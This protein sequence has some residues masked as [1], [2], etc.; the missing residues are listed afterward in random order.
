MIIYLQNVC[1]LEQMESGESLQDI[2]TKLSVSWC[3]D[4]IKFVRN[5]FSI[6]FILVYVNLSSICIH[7][8][9][10]LFKVLKQVAH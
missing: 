3:S 10:L 7:E 9:F 1:V 8:D 6:I 5:F 4:E 2:F